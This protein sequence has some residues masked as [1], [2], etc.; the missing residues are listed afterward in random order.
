MRNN[1]ATHDE[2][3]QVPVMVKCNPPT[4]TKSAWRLNVATNGQI[5]NSSHDNVNSKIRI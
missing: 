5:V 4:H 2:H 3:L 1:V